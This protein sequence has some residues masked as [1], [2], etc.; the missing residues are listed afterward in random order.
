MRIE[1]VLENYFFSAQEIFV[2]P[3][4]SSLYRTRRKITTAEQLLMFC[5]AARQL[6]GL[7]NPILGFGS[8]AFLDV[9]IRTDFRHY[10][11]DDEFLRA[12]ENANFV[13]TAG[14]VELVVTDNAGF[15]RAEHEEVKK[16]IVV[17]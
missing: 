7:C 11:V 2:L 17:K 13:I 4:S 12:V 10:D 6:H 8:L 3:T 14:D 16:R 1:I 9:H 15:V 5:P